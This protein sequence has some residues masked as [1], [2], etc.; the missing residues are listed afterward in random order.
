MGFVV[1]NNEPVRIVQVSVGQD[2]IRVH[3]HSWSRCC[4]VALFVEDKHASEIDSVCLVF[5][6][7]KVVHELDRG[8]CHGPADASAGTI[9]LRDLIERLPAKARCSCVDV[10]VGEIEIEELR[11]NS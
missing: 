2:V 10:V 4:S 7:V 6:D 5:V 9:A 11:F 3:Q 8:N 1:E